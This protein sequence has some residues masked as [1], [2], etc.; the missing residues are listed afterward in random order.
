LVWTSGLHD[1]YWSEVAVSESGP[2]TV[3]DPEY[4][5]WFWAYIAYA[6]VLL[7]SGAALLVASAMRL[8]RTL[9]TQSILLLLAVFAPLLGNALYITGASPIPA[10]DLT[11]FGFTLTGVFI[12]WALFGFRLLDLVPM[13][14]AGVFEDM[15]DGII[16]ID[17]HRRIVDVNPTGRR[18]LESIG[19]PLLGHVVPSRIAEIL[20][21]LKTENPKGVMAKGQSFII[22]ESSR[23]FDVSVSPIEL[24]RQAAGAVLVFRDVTQ[25]ELAE[26]AL[27]V[28]NKA[29][30]DTNV[31][32]R[33]E[34]AQRKAAEEALA[35]SEALRRLQ[36]AADAKEQERK[37]LAEEL[38]DQTLAQLSSII[39]ELGFLAKQS[40][41][42]GN[43]NAASAIVQHLDDL[44]A[45]VRTTEQGLRQIV[46]GIYPAVLTN[47]GLVPALRAYF[48]QLTVQPVNNPTSI[49]IELVATG[50]DTE[51]LP[52]QVELAVYRVVQQSVANAVQHA[53]AQNIHVELDKGNTHLG[54]VVTDDGVGFDPLGIQ[55]TPETGHF[56][57]VNLR[58]RILSLE[59]EFTLE[60]KPRK[61]TRIAA[62]V[63]IP[64]PKAMDTKPSAPVRSIYQLNAGNR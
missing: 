44:R 43:G 41:T 64:S 18:I 61:G 34:I 2:L 14:R 33:D 11:P 60:S 45:R 63:P 62:R 35:R 6:Y 50:L 20:D 30:E 29:L 23:L 47:L 38:H 8:F 56:G 37:R 12:V 54:L 51:R 48:E 9:R 3:F 39:V 21:L 59:G 53:M 36:V 55:N 16:V 49:K 17:R 22:G 13:A 5:P 32:L 28:A 58:D 40:Q 27:R 57:L 10:L 31:Q 25:R 46:Q 26:I 52:E 42:G 7:L 1:L 24:G 19:Q 15:P 4:G